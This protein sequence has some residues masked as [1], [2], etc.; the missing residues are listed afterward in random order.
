MIFYIAILISNVIV[1]C[2]ISF[3]K[4]NN[5][6][7]LKLY[8]YDDLIHFLMFYSITVSTYLLLNSL[9]R[10]NIVF[11]YFGFLIVL[12][13]FLLPIITEYLQYY[14]PRRTPDISDLIYDYYGLLAGILTI[15]SY[16]YVK[17]N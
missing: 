6:S 5:L 11:S 10:K 3:Y 12:L 7:Y 13:V 16:R 4:F 8:R 1:V 9:H 15:L 17:K 2:I 14:T